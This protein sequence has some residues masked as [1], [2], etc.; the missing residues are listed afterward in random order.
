[1]TFIRVQL[2][3]AQFD[4]CF[5]AELLLFSFRLVL[6]F[7]IEFSLYIRVGCLFFSSGCYQSDIR[8]CC[9]LALSGEVDWIT[10]TWLTHGP[11]YASPTIINILGIGLEIFVSDTLRQHVIRINEPSLTTIRTISN[12]RGAEDRAVFLS[13]DPFH[14]L[15]K[16][17]TDRGG[18]GPRKDTTP[19]LRLDIGSRR[20][21]AWMT[22]GLAT[23][24]ART[25]FRG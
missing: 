5:F 10:F 7:P 13:L 3:L 21:R 1:M 18:Q 14:E 4:H 6:R 12:Y 22:P 8:S 16:A 2:F 23:F 15:S 11:K 20:M 9:M 19:Q 25:I 17:W 24:Q